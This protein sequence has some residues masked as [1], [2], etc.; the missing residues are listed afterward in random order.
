LS[1]QTPFPTPLIL[2][3]SYRLRAT[4][5]GRYWP[6]RFGLWGR[7]GLLQSLLD[8]KHHKAVIPEGVSLTGTL[9]RKLAE[10]PARSSR[11]G[12][13]EMCSGSPLSH[14]GRPI[15]RRT[16]VRA[17]HAPNLLG[18]LARP[19][20]H[21]AAR[22]CAETPSPASPELPHEWGSGYA[23]AAATCRFPVYGVS[24]YTPMCPEG[25]EGVFQLG[26]SKTYPT[27]CAIPIT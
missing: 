24:A 27:P 5:L 25:T 19:S 1:S 12:G 22:I 11:F 23:T 21:G 17:L 2:R 20:L 7:Q 14:W 3:P 15:G 4:R 16:G 6:R 18:A 8:E 26:Q 10:V 9:C 13:D